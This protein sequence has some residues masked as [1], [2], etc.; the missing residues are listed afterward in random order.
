MKK[1]DGRI[2][3]WPRYF[4]ASLSRAAGRRVSTSLAV[5]SPDGAWIAA[6]AKKAGFSVEEVPAKHPS[7]SWENCG[8]IAITADN[9]E[10][11]LRAIATKML[12]A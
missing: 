12:P 3:V 7:K 1:G 4:D 5:K 9:K 10:A 11:A 8:C 2:V 6:A